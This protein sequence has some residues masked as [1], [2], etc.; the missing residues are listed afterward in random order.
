MRRVTLMQDF[1]GTLR[2][3][4]LLAVPIALVCATPASATFPGGNGKL[5][6]QRPAGPQMDLFTIRPDGSHA[7]KLVGGRAFDEKAEWSPDGRRIAFARGN[8]SG[9]RGEIWTANAKGRDLRRLTTWNAIAGA[10]TW[11]ADERI[12]YFTTKDFPPDDL[13]PSELYSMAADGSDQRRLTYD[14]VIQVDPQV[15]PA[16]GTVAYVA[17]DPVPGEPGVFD[18]GLFSIAVDGSGQKALAPFSSKRDVLTASWSPDGSRIVAEVAWARPPVE[19]GGSDRQSDLV[20][21]NAD[22]TGLR[23]LTRTRT[24]ETNPVWSPD[25]RL[26]AFTSDRHVKHGKRERWSPDFELYLM[27]ADGTRIRRLTHNSVPDLVPDW[28]ARRAA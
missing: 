16:D 2:T 5:V 14:E 17:F 28:Q 15:S 23:R 9:D 10:P 1:R 3:L 4:A 12:V 19:P 24:L 25:G 20:L 22:G 6:F 26:I 18:L 8:V 13:P 27:R 11:T 21:M 7:K